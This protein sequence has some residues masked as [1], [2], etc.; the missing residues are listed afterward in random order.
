MAIYHIPPDMKE[1]ER[2]IG[3]VLTLNQFFWLLGGFGIGM[4]GFVFTFTLFH[5]LPVSIFMLIVGMGLSLPFVFYKRGDLTLYQYITR[6]HRFLKKNH[7]L[8]NK[9]IVK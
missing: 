5:S 4:V 3:N 8:I 7:H 2:I 6:R 9:R 1:K